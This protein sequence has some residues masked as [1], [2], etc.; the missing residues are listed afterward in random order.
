M[1]EPGACSSSMT[2]EGGSNYK[3]VPFDKIAQRLGLSCGQSPQPLITPVAPTFPI[4]RPT[5]ETVPVANAGDAADDPAIWANRAKSSRQSVIGTDKQ[6]GLHVYDMQGKSLH[7]AADGKMN[8]VDLGTASSLVGATVVL[9]T[10]SDR[11]NKAVAIYPLDTGS[12]RAGQC[13]GWHPGDRAVG[14][15]RAMHVPRVNRGRQ[16]VYVSDP[17]G[18]VQA[19]GTGRDA[20]RQGPA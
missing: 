13:R 16:Y 14:P 12:G 20:C 17:D 5:V 19:V 18:L 8:N 15:L 7:F 11:T 3:I 2:I 4:V 6:G 10:A 1:V 9:V